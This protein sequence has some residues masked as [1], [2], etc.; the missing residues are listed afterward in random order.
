MKKDK[1]I[2]CL[3]LAMLLIL[4][5]VPLNSAMAAQKVRLNKSK[6]NLKVNQTKT[7]KITGTSQKVKWKNGNKKVIKVLTTNKKSIKIKAIREG[8]TQIIAQVGKKKY[9]CKIIVKKTEGAQTDFDIATIVPTTTPKVTMEPKETQ[10]VVPKATVEPTGVFTEMPKVTVEPTEVPTE[11]PKATVVPTEIP[12]VTV[13]PTVAPTA[14][15]ISTIE[16]SAVPTTVP[17]NM[18]FD[19]LKNYIKKNG[20][21]NK[22]NEK[23]IK[24]IISSEDGGSYSYAVVY[25]EI[26]EELDFIMIGEGYLSSRSWKGSTTM[27]LRKED[28]G[29]VVDVMYVVGKNALEGTATILKNTFNNSSP[30]EISLITETMGTS[31]SETSAKELCQS[32][33]R[34]SFLGWQSLLYDH[35]FELADLGF[36]AY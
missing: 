13:E 20:G 6:I 23:F 7:I 14:T 18:G 21:T 29:G 22:N 11:I 3:L 8:K 26:N 2:T 19:N 24:K 25:D 27:N 5:I 17:A 31:T 12:K 33:I 35:G 28:V 1:K 36:I 16:P 4:N 9:Y 34:L 32:T 30:I 15:P 10:T